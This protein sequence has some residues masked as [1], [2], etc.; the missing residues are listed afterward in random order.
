ACEQY[1][2]LKPRIRRS[3]W[4]QGD[5]VPFIVHGENAKSLEFPYMVAIGYV[6]GKSEGANLKWHCGGSLISDRYVLTAAH[7][8]TDAQR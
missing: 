5:Y 8:I 3:S 2:R 1:Q 6:R 7:C 4:N